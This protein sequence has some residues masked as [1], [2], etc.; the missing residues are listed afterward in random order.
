MYEAKNNEFERL[1]ERKAELEQSNSFIEATPVEPISYPSSLGSHKYTYE[2]TY[3]TGR[4]QPPERIQ[5]EVLENIESSMK[6]PEKDLK[7]K[8]NE[9]KCKESCNIF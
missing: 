3:T 1:K 8:D 9:V 7:F 4:I 5:S 6:E 2:N